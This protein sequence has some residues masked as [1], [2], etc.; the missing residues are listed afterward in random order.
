MPDVNTA[1]EAR[2]PTRKSRIQAAIKDVFMLDIIFQDAHILALNKPENLLCVPGL[3]SPENLY[4]FA[5]QAFP[6]AR[7]VHRLDMATSGIV[8]FALDHATQKH[9]GKQFEQRVIKKRYRALVQGSVR[10]R[11]GEIVCPLMCDWPN[12]PKQKICWQAGRLA[13]TV[14][15][16]VQQEAQQCELV[17]FPITGRSH[18]LRVHC[19]HIGH[20]IIGDPLYNE[21]SSGSLSR[22]MLHAEYIEFTHPNSG[23]RLCLERPADF[24]VAK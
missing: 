3:C 7:V 18:Q 9:L 23:E 11:S 17:L 21:T 6:N 4:D 22:M 14:Y 20:P 2:C 24:N 1:P 12:R 8:L 10:S 13:H 15:E 16:V 19:Q 5:R